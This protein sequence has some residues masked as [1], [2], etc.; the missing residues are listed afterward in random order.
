MVLTVGCILCGI[1]A[2]SYFAAQFTP[3]CNSVDQT[4]VAGIPNFNPPATDHETSKLKAFKLAAASFE[5]AELEAAE[6][7][8]AELDAVEPQA[9]AF[10]A[11]AC[12][13]VELDAVEPETATFDVVEPQ[14]AAFE[15]VQP[16]AAESANLLSIEFSAEAFAIPESKD[17]LG[18]TAQNE[19]QFLAIPVSDFF[20]PIAHIA[21]PVPVQLP[22]LPGV[23]TLVVPSSQSAK[24]TTDPPFMNGR[25][26]RAP[27]PPSQVANEPIGTIKI[28][29]MQTVSRMQPASR[30]TQASGKHTT[31]S[32]CKKCTEAKQAG[33]PTYRMQAVS[34]SQAFRRI[35][36]ALSQ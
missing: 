2:A 29:A 23:A 28:G 21:P 6:L 12:E 25:R 1:S 34:P 32:D 30:T 26:Q 24:R 4:T 36:S 3:R 15:A 13:A 27:A 17:A 18:I 9:A 33:N 11:A 10:E 35:K 5:A 16:D 19:V 20:A 7:E 8:A 22:A 31:Q 14:A